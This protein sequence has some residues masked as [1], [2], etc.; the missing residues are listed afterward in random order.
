MFIKRRSICSVYCQTENLNSKIQINLYKF[1]FKYNVSSTFC[2]AYILRIFKVKLFYTT[3]NT[4]KK[5]NFNKSV[6]TSFFCPF[7]CTNEC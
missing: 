7:F 6:R 2:N 3:Y 5:K 1:N 4:V